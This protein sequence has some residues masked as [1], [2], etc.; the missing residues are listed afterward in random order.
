M[1]EKDSR[2]IHRYKVKAELGKEGKKL[3]KKT[4]FCVEKKQIKTFPKTVVIC[5]GR[6]KKKLFVIFYSILV[7]NFVAF[8]RDEGRKKAG[9]FGFGEDQGSTKGC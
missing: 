7:V 2:Y 8:L 6:G 9:Q 5:F 1:Y 3:L 4:E